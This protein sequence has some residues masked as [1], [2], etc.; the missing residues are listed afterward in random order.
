VE[1]VMEII[2]MEL[3]IEEEDL[4]LLPMIRISY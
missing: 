4:E 3:E 2:I 1:I